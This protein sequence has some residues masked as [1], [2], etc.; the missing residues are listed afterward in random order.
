[1]KWW[2]QQGYDWGPI[3]PCQNQLVPTK[4]YSEPMEDLLQDH[5]TKYGRCTDCS[6]HATRRSLVFFRGEAPCDILF[7]GEAPGVSEDVLGKPFVGPAG[8][9]L[10]ELIR[11]SSNRTNVDYV[12][13]ITNIVCCIPKG[14]EGGLRKPTSDEA[15]SCRERF[16]HLVFDVAYPTLIVALGKTAQKM[17][18]PVRIPVVPIIHPAAIL[19]MP[20]V[21]RGLEYKRAL[22]TLSRAIDELAT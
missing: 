19:R 16:M 10:D 7:V 22:L 21:K 20:E 1:M 13:G 11:Q 9:L 14:P 6:L 15:L 2:A 17:I 5:E 12:F 8:H 4:K 18:Q 3:V